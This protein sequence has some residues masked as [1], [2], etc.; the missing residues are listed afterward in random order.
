MPILQIKLYKDVCVC[1][2]G[3]FNSVR[4][5]DERRGRGSVFRQVEADVFN[6]FI[7]GSLLIDLPFCGR[8]FTWYRGDGVSMSRLDR[9]LLSDKWCEKWPNSIQVAYQRG[10][11]DHVPL[12]LQTDDVN[13]APRPLRMLKCWS[14]YSGYGDFVREKWGSIYCQGWGG[15]VL[16][17]KLKL[18]KYSLKEW[19]QQHSQNLE[20]RISAVKNPIS[21]LDAK[22]EL[23]ALID[24]ELT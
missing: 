5:V 6:D 19:H 23:S 21:I 12:L 7:D 3:D 17:E 22:A 11:S 15:Y 13:W 20:G 14:E 2:R 10:L 16:K 24:E 18:L 9:F 8:I 4:N 1:V